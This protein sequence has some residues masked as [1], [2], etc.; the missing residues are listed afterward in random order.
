MKILK[1]IS[2]L[3][4][5]MLWSFISNAQITLES[6]YSHSGTY[7]YLPS[8][9]NK[10]FI[11]DVANSQCKIYNVNHSLWKTINLS[12]PSNNWLYDIKFV[13]EGLFTTDNTLCMAYI[14]YNYNETGQYYTY[15]ARVV[16]ENGSILL[17]IPGCQYLYVHKLADQS[18]KLLAY[19]YDYSVWPYT[20]QT[21]VYNL[22]GQLITATPSVGAESIHDSFLPAFPNPANMQV[23]IPYSLPEGIMQG[24]LL[25]LDTAGNLIKTFSIENNAGVFPV[26][27]ASFPRGTYFYRFEADNYQSKTGKIVLN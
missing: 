1:S 16:R 14:F 7:T 21:T 18:T 11:M 12:V 2:A 6:T 27:S 17:N 24:R 3:V 9:G 13:S 26:P 8:S 23:N 20:I 15:T 5:L 10:F 19:S 22:P 4:L 25:L